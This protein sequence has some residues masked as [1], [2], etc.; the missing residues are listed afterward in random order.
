MFIGDNSFGNQRHLHFILD[1]VCKLISPTIINIHMISPQLDRYAELL[2]KP[3][4]LQAYLPHDDASWIL[5]EEICHLVEDRQSGMPTHPIQILAI[6]DLA[7]LI[8]DFTANQLADFKWL[9]DAS[10]KA[11]VWVFATL[12]STNIRQDFFATIEQFRT[13]VFGR[14]SSPSSAVLLSGSSFLDISELMPGVESVVMSGGEQF[15]IYIPQL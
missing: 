2:R 4:F 15:K 6:D 14:V 8:Q 7:L 1:S 13:K 9:L 11:M 3:H 5:I 12:T 10:T